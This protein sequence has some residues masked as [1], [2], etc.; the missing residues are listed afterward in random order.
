MNTNKSK[1]NRKFMNGFP[2]LIMLSI[3]CRQKDPELGIKDDTE[4][5]GATVFEIE[6]DLEDATGIRPHQGAVASALGT[7]THH[8][9]VERDQWRFGSYPTHVYTLTTAG[10]L[11]INQCLAAIETL[12]RLK[13]VSERGAR[14]SGPDRRRPR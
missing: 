11:R 13:P 9:W 8:K 1:S 10:R 6:N 4:I 5:D 2:F 12:N 14:I 7:I 3:R